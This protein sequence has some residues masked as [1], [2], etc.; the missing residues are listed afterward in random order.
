MDKLFYNHYKVFYLAGYYLNFSRAAKK[1]GCLQPHVSRMMIE[2]EI[3]LF[4]SYI[5]NGKEQ[6][7]QKLFIKSG[8]GVEFTGAGKELYIKINESIDLID[9]AEREAKNIHNP[10]SG[11]FTIGVSDDIMEWIMVP[12]IKK[13]HERYPKIKLQ[14]YSLGK[15]RDRLE[16][17]KNGNLDITIS[18]SSYDDDPTIASIDCQSLSSFIVN[19]CFVVGKSYPRHEEL[20]GRLIDWK[21]LD[22][23][24]LI[25]PNYSKLIK[26]FIKKY[27][28]NL[29]SVMNLSSHNLS[30]VWAKAGVG[31]GLET[32][33]FLSK[34]DKKELTVLNMYPEL[35]IRYLKIYILRNRLHKTPTKNGMYRVLHYHTER[36]LKIVFNDEKENFAVSLEE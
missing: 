30:K 5:V 35:P 22:S 13:F 18:N 17:L 24:D 15:S 12:L 16:M 29:D 31:I 23:H 20:T 3:E 11:F 8:N 19:D 27:N 32:K 26:S 9:K 4:G 28:V 34:E 7:R 25:L 1:L 6:P 33:E 2:L 10:E 21:E 14:I 36:F